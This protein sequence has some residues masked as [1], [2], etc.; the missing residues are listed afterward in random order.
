MGEYSSRWWE[1]NDTEDASVSAE[2]QPDG[3]KTTEAS[4]DRGDGGGGGG[5]LRNQR[6]AGAKPMRDVTTRNIEEKFR[7]HLKAQ[8]ALKR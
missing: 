6:D 2:C 5:P 1:V 8:G 3:A 4:P 7:S